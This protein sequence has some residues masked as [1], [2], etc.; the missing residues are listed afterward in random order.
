MAS[1]KPPLITWPS[2]VP[3]N[4][5][6]PAAAAQDVQCHDTSQ[7]GAQSLPP[8]DAHLPLIT[9]PSQAT[10]RR[11]SPQAAA[12][13]ERPPVPPARDNTWRQRYDSEL[14]RQSS[15][16]TKSAVPSKSP[17]SHPSFQPPAPTCQSSR[18]L[19]QRDEPLTVIG[20]S[21]CGSTP[22]TSVAPNGVPKSSHGSQY[23]GAPAVPE[24]PRL[25]IWQ[26]A[27]SVTPGIKSRRCAPF[28][29]MANRQEGSLPGSSAK[30]GTGK[31][32]LEGS[33]VQSGLRSLQNLSL[34]LLL[35]VPPWPPPAP[36]YLPASLPIPPEPPPVAHQKFLKVMLSSSASRQC[37]HRAALSC[38]VATQRLLQLRSEESPVGLL[39]TL[40]RR[41]PALSLPRPH[42]SDETPALLACQVPHDL[43]RAPPSAYQR[44]WAPP[45]PRTFPPAWCVSI[46]SDVASPE[47]LR[48]CARLRA[49][50]RMLLVASMPICL[51]VLNC[52][53]ALP[54]RDRAAS[55]CAHRQAC[56]SP[57][58]RACAPVVQ[59]YVSVAA[60]RRVKL[61]RC[62][63]RAMEWGAP[64]GAAPRSN[65]R[66][67]LLLVDLKNIAHDREEDNEDE[68]LAI[69]LPNT[70]HLF[71]RRAAWSRCDETRGL[72]QLQCVEAKYCCRSTP[73]CAERARLCCKLGARHELVSRI[74]HAAAAIAAIAAQ[75]KE[76]A[77]EKLASGMVETVY[78]Q[79]GVWATVKMRTDGHI[80]SC[81]VFSPV[82]GAVPRLKSSE[83][84][85]FGQAQP[86]I[87]EHC[88]CSN[89]PPTPRILRARVE[90][91]LCSYVR[92]AAGGA[93]APECR[94][95]GKMRNER[96]EVGKRS[97]THLSY[98]VTHF[99]CASATRRC[100]RA[101][102][103]CL[104]PASM[105]P[106]IRLRDPRIE[107]G[108]RVGRDVLMRPHRQIPSKI[109]Q[110]HPSSRVSRARA[111]LSRAPHRRFEHRRRGIDLVEERTEVARDTRDTPSAFPLHLYV[112]GV[113]RLAHAP[114]RI[115][116]RWRRLT[117]CCLRLS[118]SASSTPHLSADETQRVHQP[119]IACACQRV[120]D[121]VPWTTRSRASNPR[122]PT[123]PAPD[124]KP[125][126]TTDEPRRP[127]KPTSAPA[128]AR[129]ATPALGKR[130]HAPSAHTRDHPWRS[131][132][133]GC[134]TN[135][136]R[137]FRGSVQAHASSVAFTYAIVSHCRS[138]SVDTPHAP[139]TVRASDTRAPY[140]F[141]GGRPRAQAGIHSF[142]SLPVSL[143]APGRTH[144]LLKSASAPPRILD[145]SRHLLQRR[146]ARDVAMT[147]HSLPLPSLSPPSCSLCVLGVTRLGRTPVLACSCWRRSVSRCL[148]PGHPR[149]PSRRPALSPWVVLV[150]RHSNTS[151]SCGV[152]DFIAI[153]QS[154]VSSGVPCVGVRSWSSAVASQRRYPN[155]RSG[156]RQLSSRAR[157]V[158]LCAKV[159]NTLPCTGG[160]IGKSV[161]SG[162]LACRKLQLRTINA[163]HLLSKW[164]KRAL[165]NEV[166]SAFWGSTS[167]QHSRFNLSR[168]RL[169]S[170][171]K[172]GNENNEYRARR[173][174]KNE[175][176]G[177]ACVMRL[178]ELYLAKA[179]Q[180]DFL[181]HTF[182][183]SSP[184]CV[185]AV[186]G[187]ANTRRQYVARTACTSVPRASAR[188][189]HTPITPGKAML[190]L[191]S[192]S[193][194]IELLRS[195]TKVSYDVCTWIEELR[196]LGEAAVR[197]GAQTRRTA[198]MG[199]TGYS[200]LSRS[201]GLR[202]SDTMAA[203]SM[204]VSPL[205]VW[206]TSRPSMSVSRG[207]KP[208]RCDVSTAVS[209]RHRPR[210]A[211]VPVYARRVHVTSPALPLLQ[212]SRY[213]R[214]FRLRRSRRSVAKVRTVPARHGT[215]ALQHWMNRARTHRDRRV[216]E[217]L[218]RLHS[219][220]PI[221]SRRHCPRTAARRT[222]AA[223][224]REE[225]RL[226]RLHLILYLSSRE[227]IQRGLPTISSAHDCKKDGK[228]YRRRTSCACF[229][230]PRVAELQHKGCRSLSGGCVHTCA[231]VCSPSW[232]KLPAAA[233][234]LRSLEPLHSDTRAAVPPVFSD[235]ST[236]NFSSCRVT[237]RGLWAK[238]M[239]DVTAREKICRHNTRRYPPAHATLRAHSA[240][241]QAPRTRA[242]LMSC[243]TQRS[244]GLLLQV[245]RAPVLAQTVYL[246]GRRRLRGP[247]RSRASSPRAV[248]T[249][250]NVER[251]YWPQAAAAA[252]GL[253]HRPARSQ[254]SLRMEMS[255]ANYMF[256]LTVLDHTC[257]VP[258]S[259]AAG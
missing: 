74:E 16:P 2:G 155:R 195:D 235:E 135:I 104:M 134:L 203:A 244:P 52:T 103:P 8:P 256:A 185:A 39:L 117:S 76:N 58:E 120:Q 205:H 38:C 230:Q 46:L 138:D 23:P 128:L 234:L 174:A 75:P 165:A 153:P 238:E 209:A 92:R 191:V 207:I 10:K 12:R 196:A 15:K 105:G 89:Q 250:W 170:K 112:P 124:I 145:L 214:A 149:S 83:G 32:E 176:D 91:W 241:A 154:S 219:T 13:H 215:R 54:T 61:L 68:E 178:Y 225:E 187:Q 101:A 34:L 156:V 64:S 25:S 70:L 177:L 130:V 90:L 118:L 78:K 181:S 223:W 51:R 188:H 49:S 200:V 132:W 20:T 31:W 189:M 204:S 26:Y 252:R 127:L 224:P 111:I 212:S 40:L 166:R 131:P 193:R 81:T 162:P 11:S 232:I 242:L 37:L 9:V 180:A 206:V 184:A 72:P 201:P 211:A 227:L 220:P 45:H 35:P 5:L 66:M 100:T 28:L 161:T 248:A 139:G 43:P 24:E 182:S 208:L 87:L 80:A 50:A 1:T 157:D 71:L 21:F 114:V 97:G 41:P 18:P 44:T 148:Q 106:P 255:L 192:V 47:S 233:S 30:S 160:P 63:K 7:W 69:L 19:V 99:R 22:T 123:P 125:H 198:N 42:K 183:T 228:Q 147:R 17:S 29:E 243:E 93:T 119:T 152:T 221:G 216:V 95:K 4:P 159:F 142:A 109:R 186:L 190:A 229:S 84:E 258:G 85:D 158:S 110:D 245:V 171:E 55:L 57:P 122:L 113:T 239:S 133:S 33:R 140:R 169:L 175:T 82:W 150:T 213:A 249:R 59:L 36:S 168:D 246:H 60:S 202:R 226:T 144:A 164:C 217:R 173:V 96:I 141:A 253:M 240:I 102:R 251:R 210:T 6:S 48:T 163:L 108:T 115:H 56:A 27:S 143:R 62:D 94:S 172:R 136:R 257:A 194:G 116:L 179:A 107:E 86:R 146:R 231:N 88:A 237:A 199:V 151:A 167:F 126:P 73:H 53:P 129:L 218:P 98:T 65:I 197:W 67:N 236:A 121:G 3:L 14:A 77:R 79:L 259:A 247:A 222:G 254:R 137:Y